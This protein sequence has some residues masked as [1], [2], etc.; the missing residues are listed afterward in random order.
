ML[1]FARNQL[2]FFEKWGF[3][4]DE[5]YSDPT[6]KLINRRKRRKLASYNRQPTIV[7]KT[8]HGTDCSRIAHL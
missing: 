4:P 3:E 6:F 2:K 1:N 5:A 7:N 8:V